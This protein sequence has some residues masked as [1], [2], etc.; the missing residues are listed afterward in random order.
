MNPRLEEIRASLEQR[1]TEELTS[2]LRNHDQEEWRAEVFEI[3]ASILAARGVSP[4]EVAALGPEPREVV[5]SRP[6]VT[7]G[8]YFNPAEA[9]AARLALENAGIS[10]WVLDE[11]LG[12]AYSIGVG[13]RL[14]VLVEDEAAALELLEGDDVPAGE[15][16]PE[17][18]EP[19]CPRCGSARVR[20]VAEVIDPGPTF[21]RP[22]GRRQREWKYVCDSCDHRWSDG[23]E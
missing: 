16:P 20:P 4:A 8:R 10:A 12:T 17:L 2:I 9:H 19:P 18:Q 23:T 15:V 5:E 13:T 11:V 3:V 6:L 7:V 1:T 21:A 14:Q 22:S